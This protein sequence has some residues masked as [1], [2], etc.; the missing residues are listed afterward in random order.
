MSAPVA[1]P[2]PSHMLKPV[3]C[4]SA[5]RRTRAGLGSFPWLLSGGLALAIG[6][7]T[8]DVEGWRQPS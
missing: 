8:V 4:T 3:V 7:D 1:R 5:G 6:N 2:C